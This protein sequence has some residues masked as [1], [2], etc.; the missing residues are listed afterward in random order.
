MRPGTTM[1]PRAS[2]ISDPRSGRSDPTASTLPSPNPISAISSRPFAGS[3]IRPPLRIR[4]SIACP[5]SGRA[6][7]ARRGGESRPICPRDARNARGGGRVFPQRHRTEATSPKAALTPS[8]RCRVNGRRIFSRATRCLNMLLPAAYNL[9]Y[10]RNLPQRWMPIRTFLRLA[11][12]ESDRSAKNFAPVRASEYL[13]PNWET[14]GAMEPPET[15]YTKS[16]DVHIAYQV[17]GNGPLDMVF[18]GGFVSNLELNWEQPGTNYFLS[19]LAAF[20]RLILFDKRGTGLS[21]RLAGIATLEERMDDVR[22][23]MDAAES[24]QA[25]LFGISEGG[26]M[27]ML[28][29]ATYP[30]RTRA[31]ALYGA[32]ARHPTLTPESLPQHIELVERLWGTGEYL[33]RF[34]A[35]SKV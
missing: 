11:F 22:A 30:K 4:S 6:Y 12:G 9:L 20:S 15:R 23:V 31:L 18:V 3:T 28:F 13:D 24:E 8:P 34:M 19:R 5:L 7:T 1:R 16:G 10:L 26:A 29:A 2:T 25:A 17:V 32:Y 21:D 27:C 35:P 33:S 14:E